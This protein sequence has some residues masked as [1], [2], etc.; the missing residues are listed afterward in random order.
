MI[1]NKKSH[2]L[3]MIQLQTRHKSQGHMYLKYLTPPTPCVE[4]TM[5]LHVFK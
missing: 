5:N 3:R 1:N 4:K 2:V